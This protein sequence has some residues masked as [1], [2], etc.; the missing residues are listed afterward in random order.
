MDNT[1]AAE[2]QP[3]CVVLAKDCEK[4]VFRYTPGSEAT[5]ISHLMDMADNEECPLGWVDVLLTIRKLGL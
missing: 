2:T 5:F 4:F 1:F 3:Q